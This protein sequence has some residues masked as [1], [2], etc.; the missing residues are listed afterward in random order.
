M[1]PFAR[2]AGA[3]GTNWA[4]A[5]NTVYVSS[6]HAETQATTMSTS[7]VVGASILCHNVAGSYPPTSA[8]LTT[9]ATISCTGSANVSFGGT[10][11]PWYIYGIRFRC[12]VGISSSQTLGIADSGNVGIGHLDNCSLQ[13]HSTSSTASIVFGGS[14]S[15]TVIMTNTTV[16]FGNVAQSVSPDIN[17]VWQSTG[18]VLAAG[19]LIPARFIN[20]KANGTR[21]DVVLE[22]L[23]LSQL[24]GFI[25][26]CTNGQ[27]GFTIIRDCKLNAAAV[28]SET[29]ISYG[30]AAQFARSSS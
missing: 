6:N 22:A 17:V 14:G 8:D 25:I 30:F 28:L 24:T 13:Q 29:P 1:A 21:R 5:N 20:P 23:D 19:S 10:L 11:G 7:F 16:Y 15:S 26:G 2:L 3:F 4:A 9:G 18:P 12:G 27:A